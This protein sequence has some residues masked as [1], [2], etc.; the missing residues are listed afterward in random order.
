M[1]FAQAA[2]K[3]EGLHFSHRFF[4]DLMCLFVAMSVN[5]AEEEIKKNCEKDLE[6]HHSRIHRE[7]LQIASPTNSGPDF[8]KRTSN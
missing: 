5:V 7:A 8:I 3:F 1:R 2:C 4:N 6:T